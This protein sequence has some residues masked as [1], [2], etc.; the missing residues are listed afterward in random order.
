[1]RISAPPIHAPWHYG[2]DI[3]HA[4]GDDRHGRSPE[5][6]AAELGCDSCTTFAGRPVYEAV[7]GR[8]GR[9]ALVSCDAAFTGL[10]AT[11]EGRGGGKVPRWKPGEESLEIVEV[12]LS[13]TAGRS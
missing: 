3:V 8:R 9:G 5:E 6:V 12:S 1:M 11:P 4:R 10:T 7:A 13:G 2:I